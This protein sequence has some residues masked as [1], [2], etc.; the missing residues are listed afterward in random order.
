MTRILYL[1][2]EEGNQISYGFEKISKC[3]IPSTCK[4]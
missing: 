3:V 2:L 4:D 1:K